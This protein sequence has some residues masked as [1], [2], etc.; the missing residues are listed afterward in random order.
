MDESKN[1]P[2]SDLSDSLFNATTAVVLGQVGFLTLGVILAAVA[3]GLFLDR[4]FDTRPL[5]TIVLVL[6]SVPVS[7]FIT[8][9]TV[10]RALTRHAVQP[11][12]DESNNDP[13]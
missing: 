1:N 13:D 9:R 8:V 11:E 7:L 2:R 4:Q 6:G 12:S 5:F 10:K 3:I